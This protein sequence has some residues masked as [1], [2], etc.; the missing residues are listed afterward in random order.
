[1][2]VKQL[3][4]SSILLYSKCP[5]AFYLKSTLQDVEETRF[6]LGGTIFHRI[7]ELQLNGYNKEEAVGIATKEFFTKPNFAEALKDALEFYL[8]YE[9]HLQDLLNEGVIATEK[10]FNIEIDNIVIKGYIDIITARRRMI[11]LKTSRKKGRPLPDAAHVFQ[12]SVYALTDDADAYYLHYV[13]PDHTDPIQV[14]PLPV[15]EVLTI[16][17]SVAK[18]IET[19]EF[20]PLGFLTGYCQFCQH[21]NHCKYHRLIEK[22]SGGII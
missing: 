4:A 5:Y 22:P 19:G 3:S 20:P 14:K 11:D 21:K 13:F 6:M 12:M 17:Q 18:M 1:M 15:R 8:A 2:D 16:I 9:P 10:E 7:I